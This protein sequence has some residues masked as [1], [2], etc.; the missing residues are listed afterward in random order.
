MTDDEQLSAMNYVFFLDLDGEDFYDIE[1]TSSFSVNL[2]YFTRVIIQTK[3]SFSTIVLHK[4]QIL[5]DIRLLPKDLQK[6]FTK[7]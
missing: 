6:W 7:H 3:K 5:C 2:L 4:T 1:S